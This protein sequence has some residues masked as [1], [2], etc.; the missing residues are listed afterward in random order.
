MT[1]AL[2][3]TFVCV[4]VCVF[5]VTLIP[6][7]PST[8]PKCPQMPWD[9]VRWGWESRGLRFLEVFE[10]P[11]VLFWHQLVGVCVCL[12]VF[13]VSDCAFM[14]SSGDGRVVCLAFVCVEGLIRV[15][16]HDFHSNLYHLTS[17]LAFFVVKASSS[18]SASCV[19]GVPIVLLNTLKHIVM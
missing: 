4:C 18:R 5:R 14:I 9:D 10:G 17:R 16:R 1:L 11:Y 3:L 6:Y 19:S 13:V 7:T 15:C 2:V 12:V 8:H